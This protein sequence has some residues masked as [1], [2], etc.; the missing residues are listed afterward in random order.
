[1]KTGELEWNQVRELYC[2]TN[3]SSEDLP[4]KVLSS[5]QLVQE[6]DSYERTGALSDSVY[7]A[8]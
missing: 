2:N 3:E 8:P 6:L 4:V 1:M 5:Y 7:S